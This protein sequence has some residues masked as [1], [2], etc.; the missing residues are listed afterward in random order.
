M[1]Y[2]SNQPTPASSSIVLPEAS[3]AFLARYET[4]AHEHDLVFPPT[5]TLEL[6]SFLQRNRILGSLFDGVI[7]EE[8]VCPDCLKAHIL[9]HASKHGLSPRDIKVLKKKLPGKVGHG[10]NYLDG[11]EL[12]PVLVNKV[13]KKNS[14][15]VHS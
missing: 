15:I 13:T 6:Q 9:T 10:E 12:K 14:T 7:P 1:V 11:S 8:D 3:H 5:L 2:S 4:I